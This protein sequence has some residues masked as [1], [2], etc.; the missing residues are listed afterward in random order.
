MFARFTSIWSKVALSSGSWVH[1][2]LEQTELLSKWAFSSLILA[3][4]SQTPSESQTEYIPCESESC[5]VMFDF[6]QPH[7]LYSPWSSPGQNTGVGSLSLLQG[8]FATQG[9]N[10]GL[11]H[12]RLILYQLNHRGSPLHPITSSYNRIP[13]IYK[14]HPFWHPADVRLKTATDRALH[15]HQ[16]I[17]AVA[18]HSKTGP[19][20]I[21]GFYSWDPTRV[22]VS[23]TSILSPLSQFIFWATNWEWVWE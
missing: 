14:W 19:V 21:P 6:L 18:L 5:S 16:L 20:R 9:S 8:I 3:V 11:P 1:C 17:Q 22:K 12:C 4:I 15:G 7:G 10:P 23:S 2:S 13:T